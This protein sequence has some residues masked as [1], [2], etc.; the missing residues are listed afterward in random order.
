LSPDCRISKSIETLARS[1]LMISSVRR[2]PYSVQVG[3]AERSIDWQTRRGRW[4]IASVACTHWQW[5][6]RGSGRSPWSLWFSWFSGHQARRGSSWYWFVVLGCPSI[7]WQRLGRPGE[8]GAVQLAYADDAARSSRD[9]Q[10]D[11]RTARLIRPWGRVFIFGLLLRLVPECL[12]GTS[13]ADPVRR[14]A[15]GHSENLSSLELPGN[16]CRCYQPRSE[17]W[18]LVLTPIPEL[19]DGSDLDLWM[20]RRFCRWHEGWACVRAVARRATLSSSTC[21][22]SRIVL[23]CTCQWDRGEAGMGAVRMGMSNGERHDAGV[24]CRSLLNHC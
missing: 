9:L 8:S 1:H 21:S 6:T 2:V 19:L 23:G 12:D 4:W 14:S 15:D 10:G 5:S 22:S 17:C 7:C 18:E 11:R 24:H 13:I 20:T 16:S 3:F